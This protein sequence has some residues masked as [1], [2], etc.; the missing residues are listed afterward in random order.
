MKRFLI[1]LIDFFYFPFLGKY[2]PRE[3]FRYAVCGGAA[4]LFDWLLYFVCYNYVF[5]QVNWDIGIFVFSPH[6]ASKLISSP[7]ATLAGFWLQKNITFGASSLRTGTQLVR[8]LLVYGINLLINIFG[9]KL[10]VEQF[11]LWATPSN[12]IVTV[13]TVV[14]SFLMQKHFTFR[15]GKDK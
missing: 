1:R 9:I 5:D 12:M 11:G 7:V 10:L 14:F 4:V 15:Q 3:M 13:V 8:Y 6:T 2:I